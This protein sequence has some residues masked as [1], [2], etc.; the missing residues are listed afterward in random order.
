[1]IIEFVCFS[2]ATSLVFVYFTSFIK[3]QFDICI[4]LAA[5]LGDKKLLGFNEETKVLTKLIIL[6]R[7]NFVYCLNIVFSYKNKFIKILL[8]RFCRKCSAIFSILV[9]GLAL[10]TITS[11]AMSLYILQYVN[12][13]IITFLF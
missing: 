11:I 12:N 1:M 13:L 9:S 4:Y 8:C 6:F 5:L 10:T 3:Y 2:F 7:N